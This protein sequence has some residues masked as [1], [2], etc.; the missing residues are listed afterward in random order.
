MGGTVG[1]GQTIYRGPGNGQLKEQAGFLVNRSLNLPSTPPR[2]VG[3]YL[4]I[5]PEP[6]EIKD[7]W[8]VIRSVINTLYIKF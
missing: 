1:S 5:F 4:M 2:A 8:E 6:P 7:L 3:G